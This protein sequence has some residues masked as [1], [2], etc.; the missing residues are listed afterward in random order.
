MDY[1]TRSSANI[2]RVA[3]LLSI[4]VSA[5]AAQ[6]QSVPNELN[7]GYPEN[8]IF[9]G[10][11]IEN[12]QLQNGNLHVRIPIWSAKGRGL[13]T[14]YNFEYNNHGYRLVTHCY[15][16]GGGFCQDNVSIDTLS[17]MTLKGFGPAD[18]QFAELGGGG[19]V[20]CTTGIYAYTI[21]GFF[22]REPDGT[23]HHFAP[24]PVRLNGSP[25]A[26]A[27]VN[28]STVYADDGSGWTMQ[29]DLNSGLIVSAT[30]KNGAKINNNSAMVPDGIVDANGNQIT[31]NSS[32]SQWTDTLGR[33]IL[34]N[35]SY[36]DSSGTLQ[37]VSVTAP[38]GV[39]T[40][41][42]LPNDQ[43]TY[44]FTYAPTIPT[45]L[46]QFSVADQCAE[47]SNGGGEIASITL[48]TGGQI[49][50]TWGTW[51]KG[52]REVATRTVSA[53]GVTGIWT[54]QFL[55]Q[56]SEGGPTIATVTDPSD[57]DMKFEGSVSED[58]HLGAQSSSETLQYFDGTAGSSALI[59]TVQ[60]DYSCILAVVNSGNSIPSH[61]PLPIRVTTTWNQQ[62]LV[63]KVET[64]WDLKSVSPTG[65]T[66]TWKNPIERREF[67]WGSGTVGSLLRRTDYSYRH[68]AS[69]GQNYLNA[70]IADL[71]TLVAT[72]DGSGNLLAQTQ[73]SYDG[74]ALTSTGSC[75]SGGAPGHD[76]CNYGTG[77]LVRGN[78]T[79][80]SHWLNTNNTW[81]NTTHTYDD[82]GNLFSTI[83]PLGHPTYT[84]YDDNWFDSACVSGANTHA[85]PT[86]VTNALGYRTKTS[87]YSCTSLVQ[88]T[89]DEDDLRA[90]RPG[91]TH[92][93]DLLNRPLITA[94][95]DGGQTAY[96]YNDSLPMTI[97]K[98][99]KASPDPDIVSSVQL[100]D[101][102][103]T[104]QTHL[105]DPE[106]DVYTKT[107]YD[108]LGRTQKVY[109]PTRCNPP[110]TNCGSEPTWGYVSYAYDALGRTTNVTQQD[111][112]VV[113]TDYSGNV[114]TVS[115]ET[116]RQR[117]ST[118]DALG[119]LIEVDEPGDPYTGAQASGT[120][121]VN[122]ALQSTTVGG[123]NATHATGSVTISGSEQCFT[124]PP[125]P[126]CN[127]PMPCCLVL[128]EP[129]WPYF[130][131]PV[132]LL[133]TICDSGTVSI[134]VNGHTNQYA[135]GNGDSA[136]SI[137]SGLAA[138]INGDGGAFVTATA[139]NGIVQLTSKATG[140]G[141]NYSLSSGYTF[142]SVDFGAPSFATSNSGSTLTGGQNGV[143]GTLVYD[144][145]TVTV[146]IG[147]FTAS[148][149]Y[150]QSGNGTAAQVASV[151]S[152][153]GP[154]GLS[155][156]GSP[157]NAVASGSTVSITYINPGVAGDVSVTCSSSTSQ[158]AYFSGPSFTCPGVTLSGGQDPY[159]SSLA[160]PYV[161][162]YSYD[163]LGNLT[164]AVQKGMDTSPFTICSAAPATWRPR[165][166]S[167]D[168]LA[169]LLTTYNPES[170]QT[171]YQ[172]DSNS[173]LIS[174]TDARG[175]TIN[176]NP[177]SSPIDAL[178][179]VT[180]KTY[181]D[182]TPS[183][184]YHYDQ[185]CC[186]VTS[187]NPVGRLTSANAGNTEL[188]FSYDPMGRINTQWDCPPSGIARGY[189]YVIS[190][191]YDAAGSMTSLTYPDG[192][193]VSNAYS[194]AGRST[195]VT[196]ASFGGTAVNL[197][198]YTVPQTT[199]PSTWG[200]WPTGA[201]NRGTFSNGVVETIGYN[202]RL[203]VSSMVD[204]TS[205]ATLFSKTYS[206]GSANNGTI[207]SIG[208][209]LSNA[210]NQTYSYDSLN[211]VASA[212]Q[213]DNAFNLNY[214]Y[215]AWGNM[216]ESGTSTFE[217][218]YAATNRIQSPASCVPVAQYC[219]DAAGDLLKDNNNHVY[220]YDGEGRINTVDG[221][222]TTYTYN[223][224]S[225]RVRKDT[226]TGSTEYFFFSGS[227]IA[228]L[229]PSN[230]TWTDYIFFGATR[231]AKD[232]STNGAGAQYYQN[233]HLGSARVMTDNTGT[234][235]SNCTFNPFGE[236]VS[237]SPNNA[238]NHYRFTGKERDTEDNLDD[239]GARY[240]SSSMGRWLTPDWSARP[241]TVP[242]ANFGDPQSLNLY[243]YVRNDPVSKADTD[244]HIEDDDCGFICLLSSWFQRRDP[245][246]S[247]NGNMAPSLLQD[248]TGLNNDQLL[249]NSTEQV[250][251]GLGAIAE[252]A[253]VL[254]PTGAL[255]A[256]Q[257]F[258]KGND[259]EGFALAALA[260]VPGGN[261][262]EEA[263]HVY[264]IVKDGKVVYVGITNN[265]ERRGLEHGEKLEQVV[266]MGSRTDA[267]S[268]E[269]ALIEHH[270]LEKNGGSLSNKI[271]SISPQ[272][273]GFSDYVR[274]GF[275]ALRSINYF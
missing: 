207:L 142:D 186:G 233:D 39:P 22:L 269:Q 40:Q 225:N 163:G 51:D 200:Y 187:L 80:V 232:T 76:Y 236:Q 224:L 9:H 230:T 89:K 48:P 59:K 158:G 53:N 29:V 1:L 203:Q 198:Y 107:I 58:C 179:R 32:T 262:T 249:E 62:N 70:N 87:Y 131:P 63:S 42:A 205:T 26:C 11:E 258:A 8:N 271:N 147:S 120:M 226:G 273:P 124:P 90:G 106:G 66:F 60:T 2:C 213:A 12:V 272:N 140:S 268:V 72:Y 31:W 104:R 99:V 275:D 184:T 171:S 247:D 127:P 77:N 108:A 219:Y 56:S 49:S 212:S 36:Y 270:G 114:T 16:S 174:K 84:S 136:I 81:L 235:I 79:Q 194:T 170:G 251:G 217:P 172:Y 52:G 47:S 112:N 25:G 110:D 27:G 223:P 98:T 134:T 146:A 256:S 126:T 253:A 20:L 13:N 164:C 210:K 111:G 61:I 71:P 135:Y 138:A 83:D 261:K 7:T 197:P 190:A 119:R 155:R 228:E 78:V 102:G 165:S 156:S 115:D 97:T 117:R 240:Y 160:H 100:D 50:Y 188:V 209:G 28:Q 45:Q 18:Y 245:N 185:N 250:A 215:D 157:V 154:T 257:A 211:R 43:G 105:V 166:F 133:Q 159:G 181:S 151:L 208:D 216:K 265:L 73:N 229:N 86:L 214:T 122:G 94:F 23:K 17:P 192:R 30:N 161:T 259:L 176:Y 191:L 69:D 123:Q 96:S 139:S 85:F 4:L 141:A 41:I 196:L 227:V 74:S 144:A 162:K 237:C 101:L 88:S 65:S 95:P 128:P 129:E 267:R 148:A 91:T 246:R 248:A 130:D 92:T 204:A 75:A 118:T 243:L 195:G 33:P 266:T 239:F 68:L 113:H 175:V 82:L 37:S 201:M 182:G 3:A 64:D 220:A 254:D 238:S 121:A 177:A 234:V 264:Q 10:T 180:M 173:N 150:G 252:G 189:C 145:G 24:D 5:L 274:A 202:N 221:S 132:A 242:Y 199:F 153:N 149:P 206:Y 255:S 116:S 21:G 143:N 38:N 103:R 178:N 55:G 6:G 222:G 263:V 231:I 125:P 183:V 167:Y 260:F 54:Y 109:N 93:Y 241:T 168:S 169:R 34:P 193:T 14:G 244:G 46:C 35:G 19:S 152:G 57:K 137:A 15:T 67:D 44:T 218:L